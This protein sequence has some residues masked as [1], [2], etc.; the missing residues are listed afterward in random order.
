MKS[1]ENILYALVWDQCTQALKSEMMSLADY[2][3]REKKA[4]SLWLLTNIKIISAGVD[5]TANVVV[6]YYQRFMRFSFIG[7]STTEL[8]EDYL[9][10]FNASVATTKLV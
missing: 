5:E 9:K 6:T 3:D 10:R 1:K 8:M 4:H 7:Q 2:S